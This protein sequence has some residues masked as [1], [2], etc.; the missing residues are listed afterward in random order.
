MDIERSDLSKIFKGH[1]DGGGD[2]FH[3]IVRARGSQ[4]QIECVLREELWRVSIFQDGVA[5]ATCDD[6]DVR[7]AIASGLKETLRA[8]AS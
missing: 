4:L 1:W 7:R 3:G 5:T 2:E 8:L 6:E